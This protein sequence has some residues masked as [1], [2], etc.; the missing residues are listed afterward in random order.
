MRVTF[1][2]VTMVGSQYALFERDG[3]AQFPHGELHEGEPVA[4]AARRVVAEWTGVDAPKLEIVDLRS[5]R[6][7]LA[8]VV[9][10]LLPEAKSPHTL[11]PRMGLPP[12]VGRL[13]PAY[14]EEALKTS[15]A[16]KLTRT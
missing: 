4:A 13:P 12:S 15:L 3:H 7:E 11:A 1:D 9:R 10:A 2:V 8:I 5:E 16:Y 14:V 6:S